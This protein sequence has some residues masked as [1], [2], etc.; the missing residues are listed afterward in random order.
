MNTPVSTLPR[1]PPG[2]AT[3]D[4]AS[5]RMVPHGV[6][7]FRGAHVMNP[8]IET[9]AAEAASAAQSVSTGPTLAIVLA[10]ILTIAFAKLLRRVAAVVSTLLSSAGSLMG[11]L[12]TVFGVGALAALTMIAVVVVR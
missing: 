9:L 10:L 11:L 1:G 8:A 2:R 12:A 4:V 3:R 5:P 6:H 7:R